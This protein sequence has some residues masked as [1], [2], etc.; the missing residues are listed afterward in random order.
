[1]KSNLSHTLS[2]IAWLL[3]ALFGYPF[4]HA[5]ASGKTWKLVWQDNFN[6]KKLNSEVWGYMDRRMDGCRNFMT[7]NPLCY[8]LRNGV[9]TIKAIKNPDTK[10]DTAKYLTGGI[11][12]RFR[13]AFA[14]GRIEVKARF[15]KRQGSFPA[16]WLLPYDS[17][18]NWPAD[19]EIDIME[20]TNTNDYISQAA[21]SEFIQKNRSYK[22]PYFTTYRLNT[23]RYNVYRVDILEDRLDFY[24]NDVLTLSYPKIDS[25]A[26]QGQFPFYHDWYLMIDMQ[27]TG[28]GNPTIDTGDLPFEMDVDWVKYYQLK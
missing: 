21:L 28:G 1:M 20:H 23:N 27:V 17:K 6:G 2:G 8:R 5:S 9:L 14:P 13:K 16:I 15:T 4:I 12:T 26:D 24:V 22:V 19:G 18:K 3:I 10:N 11:Y 25:L 7:S